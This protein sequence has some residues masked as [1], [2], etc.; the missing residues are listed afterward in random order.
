MKTAGNYGVSLFKRAIIVSFWMGSVILPIIVMDVMVFGID[1]R[2]RL[3]AQA[4]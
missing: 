3:R 4:E 2:K 1:I